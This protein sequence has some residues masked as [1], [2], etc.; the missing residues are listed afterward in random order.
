MAVI[1]QKRLEARDRAF[2]KL[3]RGKFNMDRFL[4]GDCVHIQD[5]K[6]K[7]W[8]EKGV[9]SEVITHERASRPRSYVVKAETGS[10]M[11]RNAWYLRLRSEQ[12]DSESE[13]ATSPTGES[14]CTKNGKLSQ[15]QE[16]DKDQ[17]NDKDQGSDK[18]ERR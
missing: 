7:T 9:I 17:E 16:S 4:V 13:P 10:Q 6:N 11:L 18:D 1:R 12:P 14:R 8:K 15:D 3:S 5:P 2:K